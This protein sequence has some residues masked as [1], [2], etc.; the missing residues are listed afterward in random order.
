[1]QYYS[2]ATETPAAGTQRILQQM[3]DSIAVLLAET[4]ALSHPDVHEIRKTCKKLR[5]LLR[6]AR[7]ALPSGTFGEADR[8]VRDLAGQLS[9]QRDSKVLVDTLDSIAQHF[10]GLLDVSALAPA[11]EALQGQLASGTGEAATS[12]D[13]VTLRQRLGH[14]SSAFGNIDFEQITRRTLF[15]GIAT[16][17]RRGRRA[18]S[19]LAA[20]PDTNN[21]HALRKQA[22]YLY[23]QLQFIRAWHEEALAPVSEKFHRLEETLGNDHDLAVLVDA[24]AVQPQL[25]PDRTRRELLNALAESRR[26]TLLSNA[27]RLAGEQYR[28]KPRVYRKWLQATTSLPAS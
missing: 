28:D 1:M 13:R 27:L 3:L 20:E 10:G 2:P 25:C 15:S 14:I 4:H 9:S 17:Y 6:M 18:Y 7:P 26:I 19:S 5:A 21:A 12:A 11:R 8:A 23:Y 24:L 16:S 22:K